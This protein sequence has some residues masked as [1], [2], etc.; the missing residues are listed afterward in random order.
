MLQIL[1]PNL[2]IGTDTFYG[3]KLEDTYERIKKKLKDT[4]EQDNPE[5]IAVSLDGWSHYHNGYLGINIHYITEDWKRKSWNISCQPFNCDHTAVNLWDALT[6]TLEDWG[7]RDR[8]EVALRDSAANMVACFRLGEIESLSCLNHCL[9][10]AIKDEL[11][12]LPSVQTLI[13]KCRKISTSS[14]NSNK[15]H[16]ELQRQIKLQLPGVQKQNLIRDCPTRWN[17][18]FH[19]LQRILDLKP[20]VRSALFAMDEAAAELTTN[21]FDLLEKVTSVLGSFDEATKM[22]SLSEASVSMSIP[23]IST[24]MHQLRAVPRRSRID[25]GVK[26]LKR[27]MISAM[28]ARFD[29]YEEN[30]RYTMATFLDPRY[31]G[32]FFR[33]ETTLPTVKQAVCQELQRAMELDGATAPISAQSSTS[34]TDSV[35]FHK[36]EKEPSLAAAMRAIVQGKKGKNRPVQT[37]IDSQVTELVESYEKSPNVNSNAFAYWKDVHDSGDK[38]KQAFAALAKKYITPPPTSVD[39]ERLF[40]SAGNILTPKRNRLH[41]ENLEKNLFCKENLPKINFEY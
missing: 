25:A 2:E 1:K 24:I 30:E 13:D 5:S 33:R 34:S 40:S 27:G 6:S 9:Q 31:K 28:Q 15:F 29:D 16:Q 38:L 35:S 26:T 21:E 32:C 39:V 23:I 8:V 3:R 7:I 37:S 36:T 10:L 18:T 22:L 17:S 4:L 41:A 20:A 14:N 19:M 12:E 11:F